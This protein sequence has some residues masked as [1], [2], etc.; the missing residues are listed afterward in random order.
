MEEQTNA[1]VYHLTT[2][3]DDDTDLDKL[4]AQLDRIIAKLEQAKAQ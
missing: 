2:I 4:E 3:A 1:I